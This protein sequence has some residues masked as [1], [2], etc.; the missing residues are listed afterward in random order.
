V[1]EKLP[2]S[3]VEEVV[4]EEVPNVTYDDIG[5][6]DTQIQDLRDGIELPYLYPTNSANIVYALRKACSCMAHQAVGK[7]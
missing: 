3:K 5:G 2:K 7:P 4:L 1:L 6:L